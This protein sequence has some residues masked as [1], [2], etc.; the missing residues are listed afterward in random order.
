VTLPHSGLYAASSIA[1]LEARTEYEAYLLEAAYEIAEH[2]IAANDPDEVIY[3][4]SGTPPKTVKYFSSNIVIGDWHSAFLKVGAPLMFIT[5]FKILDMVIEWVLVENGSSST[6]KFSE[7]IRELSG[8]VLFPPL[9]ETR[10]WLRERLCAL[11]ERLEPLRG[12][13]IHDRQF[14][15]AGSSLDVRSTKGGALGPVISMADADLRN[16]ALT[17][18]S[19][20]RYLQGMWQMNAFEEKRLRFALDGLS[21]LH[22]L[23]S[24]GQLA[25]Q[26]LEVQLCILDADPIVL[27]L[28][29]IRSDID[30]KFPQNDTVFDV[31]V[32]VLASDE[33]AAT[34]YL[35]PWDQLSKAKNT[36]SRSRADLAC[37]AATIPADLNVAAAV[38]E[39]KKQIERDA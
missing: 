27:D 29:K 4:P 26:R 20:L 24:L 23:P 16:L 37:C 32:A 2:R 12:T 25:P 21:C 11:Y 18:C 9:I 22:G 35:V 7:K 8:S 3:P 34:A 36:F 30:A 10:P 31:R 39:L 19:L 14:T 17:V 15:S 1:D 6:H 13:V 5:A 28:S 33:V 38:V